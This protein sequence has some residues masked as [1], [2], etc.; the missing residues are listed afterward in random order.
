MESVSSNY[1]ILRYTNFL[2]KENYLWGESV[3]Y[4]LHLYN[5]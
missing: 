3:R 5:L 4:A 2:K 1:P